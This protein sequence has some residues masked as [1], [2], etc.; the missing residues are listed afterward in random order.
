MMTY[1][2][3]E[4]EEIQRRC[5][6]ILTAL[7]SRG[8]RVTP[9]RQLV[10]RAL[11]ATHAHMT[12]D[13][14]RQQAAATAPHD[15]LPEPTIYRIVQRLKE[16]GIVAQTDLAE[17]GIVYQMITT[18][19]HHHLVCLKCGKMTDVADDLFKDL[20]ARI[21]TDYG[22]ETRIDHMAIYGVCNVCQQPET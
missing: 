5:E 8:E 12:I 7:R 9:Q 2:N 1:A 14:I 13:E 22:F 11:C 16:L 17:A 6:S 4:D 10:I 20:R 15:V 21:R 19:P 3:L 18:P